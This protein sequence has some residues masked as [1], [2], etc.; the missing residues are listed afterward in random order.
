MCIKKGYIYKNNRAY[1]IL[2]W[3]QANGTNL[4]KNSNVIF[5]DQDKRNFSPDNLMPVLKNEW[6]YMQYYCL[7]SNDPEITKA[8]I[9]IAKLAMAIAEKKKKMRENK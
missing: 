3:E 7:F 2:V 5:L 9:A 1:H 6:R 8:G 4:A